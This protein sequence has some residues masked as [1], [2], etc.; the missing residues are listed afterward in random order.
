MYVHR[1]PPPRIAHQC[2]HLLRHWTPD[3]VDVGGL[4]LQIDVKLGCNVTEFITA[5][6]CYVADIV[7]DEAGEATNELED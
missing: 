6:K 3:V 5:T 7:H 2:H 1:C 4:C